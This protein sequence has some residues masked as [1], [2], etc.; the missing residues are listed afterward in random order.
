V[1][2]VS[3]GLKI[4]GREKQ[5]LM[6]VSQNLTS[7]QIALQLFLSTRTVDSHCYKICR[8]LEASDRFEAVIL[9]RQRG[10]I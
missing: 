3:N 6:L 1:E 2:L 10:L 5:I 7:K 4:T 8:K 9:A